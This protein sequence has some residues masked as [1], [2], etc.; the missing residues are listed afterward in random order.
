M[1]GAW[2]RSD[3]HPSPSDTLTRLTLHTSQCWSLSDTVVG[4]IIV[5]LVVNVG[6]MS[7]TY[8]PILTLSP[9]SERHAKTG[10]KNVDDVGAN[11]D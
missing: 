2:V 9:I 7:A 4:K 1:T 11:Y 5:T 10:D 3:N 6:D 8:R